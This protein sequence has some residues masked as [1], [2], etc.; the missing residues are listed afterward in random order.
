MC[1]SRRNDEYSTDGSIAV[2][3]HGFRRPAFQSYS[4]R[5]LSRDRRDPN[6]PL[7]FNTACTVDLERC[8]EGDDR[9]ST[10]LSGI[11]DSTIAHS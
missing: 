6:S 9:T 4:S 10:T 2:A 1:S 7:S 3:I 11:V 8:G 5:P